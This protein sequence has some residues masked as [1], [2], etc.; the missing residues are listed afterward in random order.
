MAGIGER[1]SRGAVWVREGASA[2][3][4]AA[5]VVLTT[6]FVG[7]SLAFGPGLIMGA[8][9]ETD[10]GFR[11]AEPS[12][13]AHQQAMQAIRLM[14][15]HSAGLVALHEGA[16]GTPRIVLWYS[17]ANGDRLPG[18]GELVVLTHHALAGTVVAYA[19]DTSGAGDG[20]GGSS[21]P[22]I[23]P[24]IVVT[25]GFAERWTFRSDVTGRVLASG[26]SSFRASVDREGPDGTTGVGVQMAWGVPGGDAGDG[27][28]GAMLVPIKPAPFSD[29]LSARLGG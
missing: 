7:A 6:G 26:V 9:G 21:G 18:A 25:V 4:V 1:L 12:A 27:D 13:G 8:G 29:R 5:T 19:H 22:P 14:L 2:S 16:D 24:A 10:S 15:E 28:A 17:D 20:E 11:E 3:Q 23:D